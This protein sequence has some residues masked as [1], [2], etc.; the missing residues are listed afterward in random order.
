MDN[1]KNVDVPED[2]IPELEQMDKEYLSEGT[3][4]DEPRITEI[5]E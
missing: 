4:E 3:K 1:Y 2:V 5:K